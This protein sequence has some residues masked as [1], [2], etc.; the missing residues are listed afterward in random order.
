MASAFAFLSPSRRAMMPF[1]QVKADQKMNTRSFN[2]RRLSGKRILAVAALA[3]WGASAAIAQDRGTAQGRRIAEANCG[4][5]H[6]IDK[7]GE[8]PLQIAPPFR[9]LHLKYPVE[10]LEESL[11]EGIMTGHPAM[12]QF[13][14]RRDQVHDFIAFLKSLERP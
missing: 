14:F 9:T 13:Q 7:S 2:K 3:L 10:D 4:R 11:A 1:V 6:A 8:S 12:P 5:C